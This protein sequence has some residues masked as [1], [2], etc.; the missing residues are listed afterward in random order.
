MSQPFFSIIMPTY[1]SERTIELAL[2]SI[3]NQT[4]DQNEIEILVI[5]G[6]SIDQTLAI[7]KKYGATILDNPKKF[8][9]YAKQVG[10]SNAKGRFV[11]EQDSD[12]V[13]QD[14]NQLLKRK[15]FFE[16]H[17]EIH[18][19]MVDRLMPAP[20]CGIS[21]SYINW[22]GDPFS[23]IVYGFKGSRIKENKKYLVQQSNSGNVYFYEE[24]D[25]IP[26]GDGGTTTVDM[27]KARE[28]YG[29]KASSQEFAVS[30]F[31]MLVKDTKYVGCIP[32][33]CI[34]HFSKGYFKAY[35]SKL[36]FR[37]YTNLNSVEQSGYSSR[38]K[39]SKILAKRKKLFVI[40]VLTF[41]G[42]I[43]DSIRLSICHRDPSLL[44]HFLYTYY[45]VVMMAWEL[46]KKLLG[47]KG[48]GMQYG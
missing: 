3:R 20:K 40:Y 14:C 22:F 38:A 27:Q 29:E 44:L 36:H 10:F 41:L 13:Y 8:P 42:P 23:F 34:M 16:E 4:L 35:L 7:A 28:L 26:L 17:P 19:L 2:E 24:D 21:N 46:V 39:N 43:Y 1:N 11:I 31:H 33:D 12:E 32:N 6:G 47:V 15:C 25:M 18:S 37:V 9:E 45:V 48:K 5:D 30:A